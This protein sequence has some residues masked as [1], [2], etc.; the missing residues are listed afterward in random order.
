MTL[1]ELLRS[2]ALYVGILLLAMVLGTIM[3]A[4][5]EP[6]EKGKKKK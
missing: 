5:G 3:T 6:K 1:E 4:E 2:P